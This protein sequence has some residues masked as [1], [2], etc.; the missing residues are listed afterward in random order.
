MGRVV[1]KEVMSNITSARK[2]ETITDVGYHR[3]APGLY[4]Q[5]AKGGSKSW[6]FRFKSPLTAKQREMGLGSLSIISLAQA[7][8]LA[9]ECRQK[10]QQ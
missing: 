8:N 5:V 9:I 2:V 4:L 6:L 3:C 1:G 7:R 10:L